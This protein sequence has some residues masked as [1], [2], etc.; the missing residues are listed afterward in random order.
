MP[1]YIFHF[2]LLFLYLIC[3]TKTIANKITETNSRGPVHTYKPKGI[4]II[5]FNKF[6]MLPVNKQIDAISCKIFTFFIKTPFRCLYLVYSYN[7]FLIIPFSFYNQ[8]SLSF[9]RY[10]NTPFEWCHK[11][12]FRSRF[13]GDCGENSS[14]IWVRLILLGNMALSL[15]F[16]R[17]FRVVPHII[18][19]EC[20]KSI[21][22]GKLLLN[23]LYHTF[24]GM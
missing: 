4:S 13:S 19:K 9:S 10:S 3:L 20:E 8:A 14:C 5:R 18:P 7:N 23:L 17:L 16:S 1:S 6:I 21:G 24:Y 22:F 2:C 12:I 15:S 11:H